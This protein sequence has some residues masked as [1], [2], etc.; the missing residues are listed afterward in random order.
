MAEIHGLGDVL[1]HGSCV[2]VMGGVDMGVMRYG[3][4][5]A[6]VSSNGPFVLLL[7]RGQ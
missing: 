5:P 4:P 3:C 2:D 7:N 6:T 1:L